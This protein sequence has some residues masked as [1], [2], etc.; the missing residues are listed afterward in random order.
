VS[1]IL[2]DPSIVVAKADLHIGYMFKKILTFRQKQEKVVDQRV[3]LLSEIINNIR[4]VK[5][6]AYERHFAQRIS[7]LRQQELEM[8][9]RYGL[10]RSAVSATFAFTPVLAA[11]CELS[12]TKIVGYTT[13]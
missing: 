2:S 7:E 13:Y 6:Y 4:A 12:P 9:R 10:I 3:K 11:V 8:L 1:F 5:L